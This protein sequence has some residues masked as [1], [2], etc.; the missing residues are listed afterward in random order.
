MTKQRTFSMH[1]RLKSFAYAFAGFKQ[2][3]R[4]EYNAWIHAL[5]T[6]LVIPFSF[7]ME[8]SPMEWIAIVF[9]IAFVWITEMLNTAVEKTMDHLSPEEHPQV[10]L[11]KDVAA[12]AVLTASVAACIIAF[13]IYI[14]KLL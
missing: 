3:F 5:A 7:M 12:A 1:G 2:F 9:A 13:I 8:I 4:T 14:P 10:K 6:L 11:I